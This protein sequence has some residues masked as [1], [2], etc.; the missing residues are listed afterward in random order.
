MSEISLAISEVANAI[1]RYCDIV[2]NNM[3]NTV[4]IDQ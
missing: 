1:N 3:E 4:I 2:E